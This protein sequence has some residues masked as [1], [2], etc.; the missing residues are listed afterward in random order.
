[1]LSPSKTTTHNKLEPLYLQEK[2]Q[3]DPTKT[4]TDTSCTK[5]SAFSLFFVCFSFCEH[6][7]F[8]FQSNYSFSP[9]TYYTQV[10]SSYTKS[11]KQCVPIYPNKEKKRKKSV[12]QARNK[13]VE[14][15]SMLIQKKTQ[16]SRRRQ[17]EKE[18]K[19]ASIC[20][21]ATATT[22]SRKQ[23]AGQT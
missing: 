21:P 14:L 6:S 18:T 2:K 22:R 3:T 23:I 13:A 1:M 15:L 7:V 10:M 17:V 4:S 20:L 12:K 9:A 16:G 5:F 11:A 8:S 19:V